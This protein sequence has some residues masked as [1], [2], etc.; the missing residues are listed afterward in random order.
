VVWS[1][2]PLHSSVIR[3][4]LTCSFVLSL[5]CSFASICQVSWGAAARAAAAPGRRPAG[6]GARSARAN[7]RLS[8][9]AVGARRPGSASSNTTRINS[10]PQVGCARRRSRAA[11]TT[12]GGAAPAAAGG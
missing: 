9:R 3:S 11:R 5:I 1:T 12:S 4:Q 8:V 2:A 6:A 7:Q 10:A